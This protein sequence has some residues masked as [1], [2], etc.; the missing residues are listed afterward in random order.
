[1]TERPFVIGVCGPTASGKSTVCEVIASKL[2]DQDVGILSCDAFYKQLTPEESV[3][4]H[5]NDYDFDCPSA[6]DF[7]KLI[8]AVSQLRDYKDAEIPIY[9]FKTHGRTGIQT[10][11]K[12]HV[13][14]VEG[15][16]IF[17]DPN[18]R[19]LFD[20]KI[21]VDSDSDLRLARRL[22]RDITIRGRDVTGVLQQY[23]KFVKPSIENFVEPSKKFADVIIPNCN[24]GVNLVAI[25]VLLKTIEAQLDMRKSLDGR[26]C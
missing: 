7:D 24:D 14:I 19:S 6:I 5:A 26:D 13:L 11:S 2:A 21:Y 3:K 17:T 9:D 4:A 18:L 23:L 1:M 15:I 16:L 20:V 25:D 8:E 10:F 22:Q 12:R